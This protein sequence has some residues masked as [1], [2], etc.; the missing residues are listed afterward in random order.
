MIRIDPNS[1]SDRSIARSSKDHHL[2]A[3][4]AQDLGES[5]PLNCEWIGRER[6]AHAAKLEVDRVLVPRIR[7]AQQQE[8]VPIL[9]NPDVSAEVA[10]ADRHGPG[11]IFARR[12]PDD[13]EAVEW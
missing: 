13:V 4:Q 2:A 5:S 12:I 9:L 1:Q 3:A 10:V 6:H 11:A 7:L 8:Q